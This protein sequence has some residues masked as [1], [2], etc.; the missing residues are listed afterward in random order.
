MSNF[1]RFFL[2]YIFSLLPQSAANFLSISSYSTATF[3]LNSAPIFRSMFRTISSR[4]ALTFRSISSR[5]TAAFSFHFQQFHS[6][7]RGISLRKVSYEAF[8]FS[9]FSRNRG[10]TKP[11]TWRSVSSLLPSQAAPNL[12]ASRHN[13]VAIQLSIKTSFSWQFESLRLIFIH[14][15]LAQ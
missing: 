4:S 8:V 14:F 3:Q 6:L 15:R 12:T 13:L 5:S 9:V 11:L 10:K 7:V 1:S 2:K